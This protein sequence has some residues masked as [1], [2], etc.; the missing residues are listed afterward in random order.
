MLLDK[1]IVIRAPPSAVYAWLAPERLALWDPRI[2]RAT[3]VREGR[4]ELVGR[5][6]GHRFAARAAADAE[7]GRR[8][9][10]RQLAGDF[11]RHGGEFTLEAVPDGTRLHLVEDVEYPYVMPE[12]VTEEALRSGESRAADEALLRLKELVERGRASS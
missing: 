9:A 12:V 10:W 2:V 6:V 8:F 4:F 3:A 1:S 11:E 7:D 5:A